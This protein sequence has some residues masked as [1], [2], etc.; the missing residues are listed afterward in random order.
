MFA[1]CRRAEDTPPVITRSA[2]V[3]YRESDNNREIACFAVEGQNRQE[4]LEGG[5]W[6]NRRASTVIA[7]GAVLLPGTASAETVTYE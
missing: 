1:N 2:L 4:V 7:V 5:Q 6:G 3:R